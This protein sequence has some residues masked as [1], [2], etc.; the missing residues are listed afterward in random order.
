MYR[1]TLQFTATFADTTPGEG[2]ATL[3][4]SGLQL[5]GT[6]VLVNVTKGDDLE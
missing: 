4:V 1:K 3:C 6:S 2:Y 5:S